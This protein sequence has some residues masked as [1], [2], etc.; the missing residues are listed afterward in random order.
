LKEKKKKK[1]QSISAEK[2]N[3]QSFGEKNMK[4]TMGNTET[5]I[6]TPTAVSSCLAW[7]GIPCLAA[8]SDIKV[9]CCCWACAT[10]FVTLLPPLLNVFEQI[11]KK[12]QDKSSV[13]VFIF[14]YFF[15][16]RGQ[17]K[18]GKKLQFQRVQTMCALTNTKEDKRSEKVE[19]TC[20]CV[21]TIDA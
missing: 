7:D 14:I 17:K 20:V 3:D 12:K 2:Y 19:I 15:F 8:I 11:E 5:N 21:S 16:S 6:S 4:T 10:S 9:E 18:W 1:R 13:D